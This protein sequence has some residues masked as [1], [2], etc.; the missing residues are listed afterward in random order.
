MFH[1]FDGD[2]LAGLGVLG[3]VD[4]PEGPVPQR[5]ADFIFLHSN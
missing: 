5:L 4:G 2:D 1:F 3:L